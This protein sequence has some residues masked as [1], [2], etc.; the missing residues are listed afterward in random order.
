MNSLKDA[1]IE[2]QLAV[3]LIYL[4]ESS[5]IKTEIVLKALDIVKNDYLSKQAADIIDECPKSR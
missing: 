4:L 2:T 3:D 5:D 1:P